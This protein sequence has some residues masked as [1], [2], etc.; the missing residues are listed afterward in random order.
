MVELKGLQPT[1]FHSH[2]TD[3]TVDQVQPRIYYSVER[4]AAANS[5]LAGRCRDGNRPAQCSYTWDISDRAPR[6]SRTS[7]IWGIRQLSSMRRGCRAVCALLHRMKR[8]SQAAMR[9]HRTM[10]TWTNGEVSCYCC[11]S[12][13]QWRAHLFLQKDLASNQILGS[14]HCYGSYLP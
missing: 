6:A 1:E 12:Q 7:C 3:L 13:Y 4:T 14:S 2:S 9:S 5:F 8:M 10:T 11:C